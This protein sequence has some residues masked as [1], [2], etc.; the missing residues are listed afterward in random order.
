MTP[1]F[2]F[3]LALLLPTTWVSAAVDVS[4]LDIHSG[5]T[6]LVSVAMA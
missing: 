3:L 2:L 1:T 5:T 4:T 6:T